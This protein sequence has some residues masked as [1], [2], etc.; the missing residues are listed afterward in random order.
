MSTN[1]QAFTLRMQPENVEK[2]KIIAE[3]NKRSLSRQIEFLVEIFIKDYES[4]NGVIGSDDDDSPPP[5][6]QI[7]QNNHG[8]NNVLTAGNSQNVLN[9]I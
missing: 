8:G 3:K 5:Q 1:K 2:M 4:R 7:V 6:K 9:F